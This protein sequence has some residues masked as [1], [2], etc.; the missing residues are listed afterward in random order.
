[1][2]VAGTAWTWWALVTPGD[3]GAQ[4]VRGAVAEAGTGEPI[5]AAIVLLSTMAG[6]IEA[7]ARTNPTGRFD[8]AVSAPGLYRLQARRIGYA[9][10]SARI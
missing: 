9:P 7:A 1:M 4:G 2:E 3:L 6:R 8:L 5:P 10:D